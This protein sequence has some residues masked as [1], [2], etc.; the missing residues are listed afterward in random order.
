M[1]LPQVSKLFTAVDSTTPD[2]NTYFLLLAI[3]GVAMATATNA[4]P[5]QLSLSLRLLDH[6]ERNISVLDQTEE[7]VGDNDSYILVLGER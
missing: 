3:L 6:I 7:E 1:V 2:D 4:P 5:T